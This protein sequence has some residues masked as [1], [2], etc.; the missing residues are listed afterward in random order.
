MGTVNHLVR[1]V[2]LVAVLAL[3][4]L[5]WAAPSANEVA[6]RGAS[7]YLAGLDLLDQDG[8]HVDLYRDLIAGHS[9]VIYSF[10]SKCTDSCPAMV[11]TLKGAQERLGSRLGREVRFVAV[12]VDPAHDT[13]KALKA[14][15]RQ[16]AAPD[17]WVFLTGSNRQVGAALRRIGMFVEE[18]ADHMDLLVVGNMNTGQWKK[19]H[20][21]APAQKVVDLIVDVADEPVR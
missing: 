14:Y 18:P 5:A 9:V 16:I 13:P 17:G 19:I 4:G 10:F 21:S 8:H 6:A 20:G 1:G 12:T 3:A 7:N 2:A 11:M 15:A